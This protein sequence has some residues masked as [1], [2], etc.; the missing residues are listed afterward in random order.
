MFSYR[1]GD[2]FISFGIFKESLSAGWVSNTC[3]CNSELVIIPV[4]QESAELVLSA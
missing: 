3:N 2:Y 1:A 4:T